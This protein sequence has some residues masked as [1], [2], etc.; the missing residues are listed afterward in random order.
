MLS[1]RSMPPRSTEVPTDRKLTELREAGLTVSQL[2]ERFNLSPRSV[3]QRL[4]RLMKSAQPRVKGSN[5][6]R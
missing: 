5:W 3:N 1:F 2:A 4:A 6:R